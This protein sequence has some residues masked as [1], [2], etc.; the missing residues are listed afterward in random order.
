VVAVS[1]PTALAIRTAEA[2]GITLVAIARSDGFE[3][4]TR[5]ER[6]VFPD[7]IASSPLAAKP[8]RGRA[9]RV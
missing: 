7:Q 2:A 9:R 8:E 5:P 4:F 1:A 6:I 3:V